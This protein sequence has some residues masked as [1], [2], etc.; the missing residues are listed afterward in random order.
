MLGDVCKGL[1]ERHA[2]RMK[3]SSD[4]AD[5]RRTFEHHPS[6]ILPH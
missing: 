4:P 2:S 5:H 3:R 1:I 6:S